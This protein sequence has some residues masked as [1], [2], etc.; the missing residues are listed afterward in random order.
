VLALL[1]PGSIVRGLRGLSAAGYAPSTAPPV[2][3]D[4]FALFR[5]TDPFHS[6]S[7]LLPGQ[8]QSLDLRGAAVHSRHLQPD[9]DSWV[10]E[11]VAWWIDP[12][13]GYPIPDRAGVLRYFV[14]DAGK[15]IWGISRE[16]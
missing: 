14:P 4:Y 10:A 7:I 12:E 2:Q 8:P 6:T 1:V 11:F 15:I 9:A 16:T 13:K 3:P 5:R